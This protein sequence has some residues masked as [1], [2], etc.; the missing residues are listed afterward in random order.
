MRNRQPIAD[1]PAKLPDSTNAPDSS[2]QFGLI[3]QA[4]DR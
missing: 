3:G 1:P 2:R 4:P